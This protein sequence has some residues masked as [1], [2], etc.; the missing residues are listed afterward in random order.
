MNGIVCVVSTENWIDTTSTSI[1]SS[2]SELLIQIF[3]VFKTY[4][5]FTTAMKEDWGQRQM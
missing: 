1:A 2:E 5:S 3:E 4:T